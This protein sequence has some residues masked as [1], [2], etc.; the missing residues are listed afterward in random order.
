MEVE[1]QIWRNNGGTF[2][3]R[4]ARVI[5]VEYELDLSNRLRL[6]GAYPVYGS[7]FDADG[8][9]DLAITWGGDELHVFLAHKGFEDPVEEMEMRTSRHLAGADLDGDG[10][11]ELVQYFQGDPKRASQVRV[12]WNRGGWPR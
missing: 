6:H 9:T 12:F 5:E 3:N 4:N 2:Q 11:A 10:R 7:D 1:F 8:R